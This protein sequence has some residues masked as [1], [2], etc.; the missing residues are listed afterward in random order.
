MDARD[1]DRALR[2][3]PAGPAVASVTPRAARALLDEQGGNL[4]AA[5]RAAGMPRT[6]FRKLLRPGTRVD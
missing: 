5:A 2:G 6:S 1:I 3:R 4:S